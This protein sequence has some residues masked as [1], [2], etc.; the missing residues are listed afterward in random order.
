MN[1]NE[2]YEQIQNLRVAMKAE[3]E[4]EK[5]KAK[6]ETREERKLFRDFQKEMNKNLTARVNELKKQA[7]EEVKSVSE[8]RKLE[9]LQKVFEV[10]KNSGFTAE[11]IRE[12]MTAKTVTV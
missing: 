5:A 11:E 1:A 9:G 4:A 3:R 10:I 6:L 12:A 7:A 8:A 2:L